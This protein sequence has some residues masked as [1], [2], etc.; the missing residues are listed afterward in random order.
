MYTAETLLV[1]FPRQNFESSVR[2]YAKICFQLQKR[3]LLRYIGIHLLSGYHTFPETRLYW[4]N[5]EDKGVDV[6]KIALV[7]TYFKVSNETCIKNLQ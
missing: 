6:V 5:N 1:I 2:V 4:S 7:K 3:E